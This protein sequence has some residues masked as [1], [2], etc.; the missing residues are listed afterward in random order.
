[1]TISIFTITLVLRVASTGNLPPPFLTLAYNPCR[2]AE[3]FP[4]FRFEVMSDFFDD[5]ISMELFL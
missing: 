1:M 2:D 3:Y 4:V 5:N